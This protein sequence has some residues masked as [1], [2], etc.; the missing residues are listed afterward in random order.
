MVAIK[1]Q[2]FVTKTTSK[3]S[4]TEIESELHFE[5]SIGSGFFSPILDSNKIKYY[6]IDLNRNII[7]LLKFV[8]TLKKTG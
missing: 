6:K 5:S 4:R 7:Y 1:L 8:L 3:I 2:D